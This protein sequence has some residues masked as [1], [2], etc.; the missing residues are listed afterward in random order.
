MSKKKKT[1]TSNKNY[2]KKKWHGMPMF[3]CSRCPW[4]TMRED[5]M[6][7]HVAKHLSSEVPKTK[8]VK[9]GLVGPSGGDIVKIVD[10]DVEPEE[11]DTHG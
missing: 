6:T 1:G 8:T 10:A 9:T 7:R 11:G 5:E 3:A 2:S 4:S